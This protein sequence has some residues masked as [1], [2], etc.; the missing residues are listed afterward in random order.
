MTECRR[1]AVL[2]VMQVVDALR[3][4]LSVAINDRVE[5]LELAVRSIDR[6]NK[7]AISGR[8][9]DAKIQSDFH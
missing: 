4:V 9:T 2:K 3:M 7:L 1:L 5:G 6:V 8:E